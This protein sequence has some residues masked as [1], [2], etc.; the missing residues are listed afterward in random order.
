MHSSRHII[1][2]LRKLIRRTFWRNFLSCSKTEKFHTKESEAKEEKFKS[3]EKEKNETQSICLQKNHD[4]G[5]IAILTRLLS[6]SSIRSCLKTSRK[7]I[8]TKNE[9]RN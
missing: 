8:T 7:K 5:H 6:F 1:Y 3:K 2:T 4:L 9:R